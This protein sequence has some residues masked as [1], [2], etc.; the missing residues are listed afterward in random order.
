M[1]LP[2]LKGFIVNVGDKETLKGERQT[3]KQTI[4]FKVP[5]RTIDDGFGGKT[6]TR[7]EFFEMDVMNEKIKEET[8]KGLVDKKIIVEQAF[9]NGYSFVDPETKVTKYGK[10][11][12]VNRI[13]EFK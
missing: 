13:K 3:I 12:T 5:G 7:D 1:K 2:E 6:D 11:I 8:L 9:L 4:L 10:S